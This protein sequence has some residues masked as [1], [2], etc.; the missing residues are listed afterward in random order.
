V[1]VLGLASGA[2]EE[3][4]ELARDGQGCGVAVVFFDEGEGQVDAG[5][6]AG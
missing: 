3:H 2:D 1:A 4:D 5:G 6:D